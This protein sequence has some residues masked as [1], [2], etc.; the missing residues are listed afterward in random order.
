MDASESRV[1]FERFK[2]MV[3]P[4]DDRHRFTGP[5]NASHD[6][7][8]TKRCGTIADER[9]VIVVMNMLRDPHSSLRDKNRAEVDAAHLVHELHY[10]FLRRRNGG[11]YRPTSSDEDGG[12]H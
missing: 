7:A 5:E 4:S 12:R 10:L 2:F 3:L 8:N 6:S 9:S 11:E 1:V